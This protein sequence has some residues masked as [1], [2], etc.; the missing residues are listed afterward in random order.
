MHRSPPGACSL[1]VLGPVPRP[2]SSKETNRPPRF[3]LNLCL[4]ATFIDPGESA[5]P[6]TAQATQCCLPK[7]LLRRHSQCLPFRG[8]IT[9]PTNSL[10]TLHVLRHHSPRKTRFRPVGLPWSRGTSTRRI[11][12]GDFVVLCRSQIM[13]SPPTGFSWRTVP[14]H[15]MPTSRDSFGKLP[16]SNLLKFP[17]T[18]CQF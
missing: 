10:S 12:S 18:L 16:T 14:W 2:L 4:R 3:L 1:G 9:W 17:V 11:H 7:E 8:S 5:S 13:T 6:K 15:I